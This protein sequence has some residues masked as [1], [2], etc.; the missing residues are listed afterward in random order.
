[1]NTCLCGDLCMHA[2]MRACMCMNLKGYVYVHVYIHTYIH[3]CT[4]IYGHERLCLTMHVC[5]GMLVDA[6][7][8]CV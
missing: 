4:T 5:M 3:T 2:C 6:C 7:L 8:Y 1:M